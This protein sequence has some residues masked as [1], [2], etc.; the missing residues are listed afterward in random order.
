MNRS[1]RLQQDGV[2]G[3][4]PITFYKPKDTWGVFSNFSPHGVYLPDPFDSASVLWYKTGEHRFQAMKAT[5]PE[6]HEKVRLQPTPYRAKEAGGRGSP[7]GLVLREGWG[8]RYGDL[9]WYVM[10]ETI[11][12]KTV[13]NNEAYQAL[14]D[15]QSRPIYE[16]SPKDDIWG[17]RFDQDYRGKNLLGKCWMTV[18]DILGIG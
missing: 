11:L 12:A 6:I 3:I 13:Q 14:E 9:C 15:A 4:E 5:T 16:D 18:R 8:N 7:V 10:L 1:E 17:W 2:E